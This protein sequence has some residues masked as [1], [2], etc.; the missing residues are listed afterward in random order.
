MDLWH[1]LVFSHLLSIST[2]I[3]A[4]THLLPVACRQILSSVIIH[5]K[6][7]YH[8]GKQVRTFALQAQMQRGSTCRLLYHNHNVRCCPQNL[9][10]AETPLLLSMAEMFAQ[11]LFTV[12]RKVSLV[13]LTINGS[14]KKIPHLNDIQFCYF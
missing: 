12:Y 13:R 10:R 2:H 7:N 11:N 5:T 14:N 4:N 1:H 6:S 8:R 3:C 9:K